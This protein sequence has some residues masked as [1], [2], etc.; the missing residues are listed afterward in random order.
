MAMSHPVQ[1]QEQ[2]G[3][4]LLFQDHLKPRGNGLNFVHQQGRWVM[5]GA[6]PEMTIR[7]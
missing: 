4:L 6:T 7:V 1:V 3:V 2:R 5:A